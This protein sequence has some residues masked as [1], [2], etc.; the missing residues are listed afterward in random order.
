MDNIER[1]GILLDED[2]IKVWADL[3]VDIDD[4]NLPAPDTFPMVGQQSVAP[5]IFKD[6]FPRWVVLQ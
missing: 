4:N 3:E 1:R 6:F 5:N 2:I